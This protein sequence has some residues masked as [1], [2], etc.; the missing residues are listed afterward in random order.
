MLIRLKNKE[1]FAF[2]GLWDSWRNPQL[3]EE[4]LNTFT[5]I[6]TDP[7]TRLKQIHNRMP[8]IYDQEMGKQW[9]GEVVGSRS[10]K[11]AAIMR[12][13]RHNTWKPTRSPK[14]ST[15]RPTTDLS[16]PVRYSAVRY[17]TVRIIEPSV[18]AALLI[19]SIAVLGPFA[20]V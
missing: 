14:W 18:V 13:Y 6:T 11:L 20:A 15:R 2:A 5:I 4:V 12:H 17:W 16:A 3:P 8:V 7:N 19:K 10:M 1:P 9:L